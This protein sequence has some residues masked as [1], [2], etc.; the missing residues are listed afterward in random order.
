MLGACA[1][2]CCGS[3]HMLRLAYF[4]VAAPP[5]SQDAPREHAPLGE[6]TLQA[7]RTRAGAAPPLPP[8]PLELAPRARPRRSAGKSTAGSRRTSD[9]RGVSFHRPSGKWRARIKVGT[10]EVRLGYHAT[11]QDAARRYD[12]AARHYHGEHAWLNFGPA[13]DEVSVPSPDGSAAPALM[14]TAQHKAARC[15]PAGAAAT[16]AAARRRRQQRCDAPPCA[17]AACDAADGGAH[18]GA[19]AREAAP[20][21]PRSASPAPLAC[22]PPSAARSGDATDSGGATRPASPQECCGGADSGGVG[23]AM[24]EWAAAALLL[25]LAGWQRGACG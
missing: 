13:A 23:G 18:A 1:G 14:M 3:E 6:S 22:T 25:R 12:E 10:Q 4:D 7:H 19:G 24:H 9:F 21:P 5:A 20:T 16:R 2:A 8:A 17:P 15:E 11:E